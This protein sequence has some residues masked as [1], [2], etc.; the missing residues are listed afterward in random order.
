MP[1]RFTDTGKWKKAWFME[2]P[3]K[4]K[5][6]WFYILDNCT[7]AGIW[8]SN[9]NLAAFQIGEPFEYAEILRVF[10]EQIHEIGDG[11]W[12]IKKFIKF[13]YG[14]L[15]VHCNPHLQVIKELKKYGIDIKKIGF[16]EASKGYH[17]RVEDQYKDKD[18]YKDQDQY[19]YSQNETKIYDTWNS[20]SCLQRAIN[21]DTHIKQIKTVLKKIPADSAIL[22]ISNYAKV[23]EHS[24]FFDYRWSLSE[25]LKRKATDF[26]DTDLVKRKYM[27]S[28]KNKNAEAYKAASKE[29][30][31]G[32]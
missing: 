19:I 1:K 13:Q 10:K 30:E 9:I 18:Q 21:I 16:F 2:L 25:F 11:K 32:R 24:S 3:V 20:F 14:T 31:N 8:E 15:S 4:Y 7:P 5:C 26:A 6:L 17:G 12:F 27:G 22:A 29:L 28:K 23:L